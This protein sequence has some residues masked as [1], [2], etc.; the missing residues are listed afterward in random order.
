MCL[1]VFFMRKVTCSL[2]YAIDMFCLTARALVGTRFAKNLV[3]R[4]PVP[5]PLFNLLQPITITSIYTPSKILLPC[6]QGRI[7]QTIQKMSSAVGRYVAP[8]LPLLGFFATLSHDALVN[9][10]Y[11]IV[12]LG[13][14]TFWSCGW[15]G[16]LCYYAIC[17]PH[18]VLG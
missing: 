6:P 9:F 14:P 17:S 2:L 7:P 11:V 8:N 13:W 5:Y 4:S 16:L 18:G 1:D 10:R 3:P 15:R 12:F